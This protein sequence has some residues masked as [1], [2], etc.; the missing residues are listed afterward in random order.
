VV[1]AGKEMPSSLSIVRQKSGEQLLISACGRTCSIDMQYTRSI[2]DLQAALQRT[3][4]MEGQS[5]HI[6][7]INGQLLSTDMQVSDAIA[8]GLTPLCATLPDKSLHHLENRREE[9]A[10]MQWKLIRDQMTQ[11]TNQLNQLSRQVSD[12]TFNLQAHQRGT[13]SNLEQMRQDVNNAID[14]ERM[15]TK[16]DIHPVQEAVNGAILLINSERGKRELSVQGF[17]KHIHGLCDMLDNERSSRR[18][19]CASQFALIQELKSGL[20][21]ERA[22]RDLMDDGVKDCRMK[23]MQ[24]RDEYSNGIQEARE[25]I[26]K[27]QADANSG[28]AESGARF[29]ELEDRCAAIESNVGDNNMF[30]TDSLD[31][32]NSRQEASAKACETLRL[33][34]KYQEGAVAN[35]L[36]RVKELEGLIRQYDMDS[37]DQ[38][39]R[40]KGVRDESIR[41]IQQVWGNDLKKQIGEVEKRLTVRLERE[42]GEREKNFKAIIDEVKITQ[43][44]TRRPMP[45]SVN[46]LSSPFITAI[47]DERRSP[48][49]SYKPSYTPPVGAEIMTE[50]PI[51]ASSFVVGSI[52]GGAELGELTYPRAVDLRQGSDATAFP[53]GSV[54][55]LPAGLQERVRVGSFE[56]A[57]TVGSTSTGT[58]S[59]GLLPQAQPLTPRMSQGYSRNGSPSMSAMKSSATTLTPSAT[60]LNSYTAPANSVPT[61]SMIPAANTSTV[62]SVTSG[63]LQAPTGF[64]TRGS[65]SAPTGM[66]NLSPRVATS[67]RVGATVGIPG[68]RPTLPATSLGSGTLG[69]SPLIGTASSVGST[70]F[71]SAGSSMARRMQ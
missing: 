60:P 36:E 22:A 57:R 59:R 32:L 34:A 45:S 31:K 67:P 61:L 46:T 53:E 9:L 15:D 29:N 68:Y 47:G 17:E 44:T 39:Q 50:S 30:N 38:F 19:E 26:G 69:T 56:M 54:N 42:S 40:E 20:E 70:S 41:R 64:E 2:V 71:L 35:S 58:I 4:Q 18:Q 14:K 13:E 52:D 65:F 66:A 7:D 3:L 37:R 49:T 28:F 27:A 63:S 62:S 33:N 10:Q 8:Q 23:I 48:T 25:R 21:G 55:T 1:S 5:F 6:L 16:A 43:D 12:L 11:T 24:F 51:Q